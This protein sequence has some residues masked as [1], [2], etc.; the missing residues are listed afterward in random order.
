MDP[1]QQLLALEEIRSLK[2]RYFR[3]VDTKDWDGLA[4]VFTADAVFDRS[5][6][7]A[8]CDPWTGEWNPPLAAEQVLVEGCEAVLAMVRK[9]VDGLA[10]VHH[11]HMPEI[12]VHD[13]TGATGLWAMSDEL[14][15]REGNL[16]V[17]GR[18]HYHEAYRNDGQGWRIAYC[19][20]TR[21]SLVRGDL[22]NS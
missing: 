7:G 13:A 22:R 9:A 16:K 4:E 5:T 14:R 21:L 15:D 3:C 17:V 1:L 2:A 18:G 11:G 20:L 6:G 8:V 19:K 12:E 10:T